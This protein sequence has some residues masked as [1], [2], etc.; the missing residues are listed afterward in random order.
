MELRF[1]EQ[2]TTHF[3]L[4]SKESP[5]FVLIRVHI[6]VD[7]VV[8]QDSLEEA[9]MPDAIKHFLELNENIF[10]KIVHSDVPDAFLPT[11][12]S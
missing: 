11:A 1:K 10:K 4:C 8:L 9:I 6:G 7:V 5:I 12:L 3:R 2:V